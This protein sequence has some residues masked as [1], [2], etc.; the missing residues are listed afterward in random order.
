MDTVKIGTIKN[1]E[2]IFLPIRGL[3][4]HVRA[5]GDPNAPKILML[6]GWMDVSASFQF[7]VDELRRDWRVLAPD[8]RGFGLTDWASA[9]CYWYPDYLADLDALITNLQPNQ[10]M[11]IVGHS[12]GG[13][14]ASLYAGIRP[15]RVAAF[16]NLEGLGMRDSNPDDAPKKYAQWLDDLNKP[17]RLRSYP[18]YDD[19]AAR[20]LE[21]NGRL[22]AER[23][24]FL[25][26]HWGEQAEDGS[27][28]LRSDPNH[29]RVNPV[30][31][32]GAEVAACLK[33]ISAPVLWVEGGLTDMF[34]K[35]RLSRP[36]IDARKGE[37]AQC[38]SRTIED[39]GHMMHHEKPEI[40][41]RAIEG[42]LT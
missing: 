24:G 13:N 17:Q 25:A 20:L 34:S 35:F 21:S 9:D 19:L 40:I 41:A 7:V 26:R 36:E 37:I 15:E 12:M 16:V 18:S 3:N 10:A 31:Y 4:Y 14:I 39:A 28:N 27:I 30:L 8:W 5:W 2:S 32:R 11:N 33:R 38:E 29:K 6:H 23:A 1:S 42:F 22:S